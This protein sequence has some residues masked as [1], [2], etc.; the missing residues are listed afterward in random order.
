[1][2]LFFQFCSVVVVDFFD[3]LNISFYKEHLF[4]FDEERWQV[5]ILNIGSLWLLAENKDA[6]LSCIKPGP[7]SN[8]K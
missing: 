3:V 7:G 4:V 8:A 1:M 6:A 2:L 5:I